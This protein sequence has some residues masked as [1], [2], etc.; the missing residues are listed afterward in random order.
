[1]GEL[2]PWA[3]PESADH[4]PLVVVAAVP[5]KARARAYLSAE[6]GDGFELVD[7]RDAG[8]HADLI[9][10][11]P[12]S[13]QAIGRLTAAF[14]DARLIVMELRDLDHGIDIRGPVGRV[15]DAGAAAYYVAPSAAAL[16]DFLRELDD[17]AHAASAPPVA[18]ADD[19]TPALPEPSA[20]D[21]A[22]IR[23]VEEAVARRVAG[24]A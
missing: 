12:C 18:D 15:L 21:D 14:P 19:P 11:P 1:M 24:Q 10:C 9:L 17:R 3:S 23:H 13:P 4:R 8:D 22:I 2:R 6:L 7:I 16:G 20:L 5:L